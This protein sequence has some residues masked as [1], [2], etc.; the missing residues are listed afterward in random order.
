MVSAQE[1][2]AAQTGAAVAEANQAAWTTQGG[3][4]VLRA[5][6]PGVITARFAD[7]GA[8]IQSATAGQTARCPS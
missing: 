4:R 8:L 1:V 3:Y 5:P 6:F 7:P 2:E